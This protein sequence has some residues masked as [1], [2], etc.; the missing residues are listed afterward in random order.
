MHSLDFKLFATVAAVGAGLVVGGFA[1]AGMSHVSDGS[2]R[3]S[4]PDGW[5]ASVAP[6]I[7]SGHR[8]AWILLA[9]FALS[10]NAATIEGGPSVPDHKVLVA[11]GDFVPGGIAA[12]WRRVSR[13][14][15]PV[16]LSRRVSWNVRLEG[17][18]LR[19]TA[20][21]G[22]TPTNRTRR[23]VDRVLAS[24]THV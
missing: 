13:V 18:A 7:Q 9:D 24:I 5:H 10:A 22:S 19:L 6:G 2:V 16:R 1:T 20:S 11:V 12:D 3:V 14:V 4:L 17:R 23:A 8:V 21:F 15:L